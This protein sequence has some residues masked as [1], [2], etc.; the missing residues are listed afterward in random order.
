MKRGILSE[1]GNTPLRSLER[2]YPHWPVRLYAKLEMFNPGGSIKDRPA[3]NMIG[4]AMKQGAIKQGTTVVESS[5]GNMAI[6][7]AQA[8]RYFGLNLIVVVDPKINRHTRQV[9]QTYGVHVE[10]VTEADATGNYLEARLQRVQELVD[11]L[12]DAY[13]PN[14]YQNPA[15]PA[16]HRRTMH[17]IVVQMQAPPDYLLAATSTCGTI[18]G[19]AE[20][21]QEHNLDTKIIAVDAEGSVLFG[22]PPA[23]RLVPG[24]GAGRP[25]GLL[26]KKLIDRVV[27]ISDE[28]SIRGCH[29]LLDREAILAGGSSGAVVAATHALREVIP[30]QATCALIFPDSGER[31]LATIYNR[32]WLTEHFDHHAF[33]GFQ[34]PASPQKESNRNPTSQA[35]DAVKTK[36]VAIIGAGPKG[37]Y[38]FERLAAQFTEAPVGGPVEIHV[39]NKNEYFGAGQVYN[40]TQPEYLLMNN[41]AGDINMWVDEAPAPVVPEL[42]PLTDWLQLKKG[43]EISEED[44]VSRAWVGEYLQDGFEA[45]AAHLPEGISARNI[46]G[47]VTDLKKKHGGYHL[48]IKTPEGVTQTLPN[49]YDFVL[50]ATGHSQNKLSDED[51]AIKTFAGENED[52]GFIPHIYPVGELASVA[53]GSRVAIRG[54]GLTFVDAVLALTEG[55]GGSF[56]RD[57]GEKLVYTPSG[58]EP[59]VMVPFSRSGRPMVPRRPAPP[60]TVPVAFFTDEALRRLKKE[61]STGKLHFQQQL[62]PLLYKEMTYAYYEAEMR[63][64]GFNEDLR[65]YKTFREVQQVIETYHEQHADAERFNPSAFLKPRFEHDAGWH[66][67]VQS[68]LKFFIREAKK[69]EIT[70]PWAAVTAVWR[71]ITPVFGRYYAFGGLEPESQR[72]FDQSFRRLLN[73]ITYGPPIE[74]IEKIVALMDSGLLDFRFAQ[75]PE[76]KMDKSFT[77]KSEDGR[78]QSIDYLIDARISKVDVSA[79]QSPL[80]RNLLDHGLVQMYENT[81]AGQGYQP[82]CIALTPEGFT[83]DA[84]GRANPSLAVTGTP[85]EGVLFDNDALARSRNNTASGWAACVRNA[86]MKSS[87]NQH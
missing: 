40:P 20:Y 30:E 33:A 81:A 49:Q 58:R 28:E 24:H 64:T 42:L 87:L 69:G 12:T 76:L 45:I 3:M 7:L 37:T 83:L 34:Q 39:F 50:L 5:S 32:E 22:A 2:L 54:L 48:Q 82:G 25:S 63:R 66:E 1:I 84:D 9:L 14:Q 68:Y 18:M 79:D 36:K 61:S 41:H 59:E 26:D 80:Y 46:V 19:C 35:T 8:C 60:E 11:E 86:C 67:Q 73:R 44:Y 51:Q 70:S 52:I 21:V 72:Y 27:H 23:D 62:Q 75:H 77:L 53:T 78:S 17:E 16:A 38:G 74:S 4:E 65:S 55:R 57:E 71:K 56:E 43:V 29:Q 6:G 13:W 10:Q 47:E 15:N 85:T 31:Y